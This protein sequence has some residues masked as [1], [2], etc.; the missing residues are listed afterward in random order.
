MNKVRERFKQAEQQSAEDILDMH[1]D[2]SMCPELKQ[3]AIDESAG[4]IAKHFA[5]IAATHEKMV[6]WIREAVTDCKVPADSVE[7]YNKADDLYHRGKAIL[8]EMGEIE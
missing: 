6:E 2:F 7:R 5:P 4:F 3:G 8:R 1:S